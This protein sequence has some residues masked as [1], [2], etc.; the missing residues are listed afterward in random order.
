V[1]ERIRDAAFRGWLQREGFPEPVILAVL[2]LAVDAEAEAIA[3]KLGVG[4]YEARRGEV[5][6]PRM[7]PQPGDNPMPFGIGPGL[8]KGF[9]PFATGDR[10]EARKPSSRAP[11]GL[12]N[13]L[14]EKLHLGLRHGGRDAS[15]APW[16]DDD[17]LI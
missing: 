11:Q 16:G 7:D 8:S 6:A 17:A 10:E 4:L 13:R 9:F 3:Q 15:H 14:A 12:F 5:V 2:G 1:L